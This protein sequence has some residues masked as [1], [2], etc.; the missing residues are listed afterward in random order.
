[1][2]LRGV[3]ARIIQ[4]LQLNTTARRPSKRWPSFYIRADRYL[5]QRR[6]PARQATRSGPPA[7]HLPVRSPLEIVY[8]AP[9]PAPSRNSQQGGTDIS[10]EEPKTQGTTW[11]TISGILRRGLIL[12]SPLQVQ[13]YYMMLILAIVVM[14]IRIVG[15]FFETRRRLTMFDGGN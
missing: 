8:V 2:L 7:Q 1:M 15:G 13:P 11:K 5:A 9:A 4:I 10:D 12:A 14:S 6:Y 3:A